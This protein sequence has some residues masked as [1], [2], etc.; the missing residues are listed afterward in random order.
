M[1]D[2]AR[3]Y[4]FGDRP[5]EETNRFFYLETATMKWA[6]VPRLDLRQSVIDAF[7]HNGLVYL[8]GWQRQQQTMV[9]EFNPLTASLIRSSSVATI[10]AS[11]CAAWRTRSTTHWTIGLPEIIAR[12]FPGNRVEPQRDGITPTIFMLLF[13]LL[14]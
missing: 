1:E 6:T 11:S 14:G 7:T 13:L 8:L 3:L 5:A 2:P 10:T 9:H 4:V 12:L